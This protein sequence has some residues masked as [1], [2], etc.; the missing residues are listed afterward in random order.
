MEA[1]WLSG[2]VGPPKQQL[3]TLKLVHGVLVSQ[4]PFLPSL[5]FVGLFVFALG[6]GT[7]R[8]DRRTASI[9]NG[10]SFY[11]G[12]PHNNQFHRIRAY[13]FVVKGSDLT[14]VCST[15]CYKVGV[16]TNVPLL[17]STAP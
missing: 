17:G 10:T 8:T 15:T 13:N 2:T 11:E 7:G 16:I 9:H 5:V 3:G 14:K 1:R 12:R 6:G 4:G